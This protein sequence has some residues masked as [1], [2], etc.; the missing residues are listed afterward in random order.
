MELKDFIAILALVATL[1]IFI[2]QHLRLIKVQKQETYQRLELAANEVFR[3]I[4]D[5]AKELA[6]YQAPQ[7]D[8][9]KAL[10]NDEIADN[11]IYQI[12]NLFEMAARLRQ[13]K[14]F[15][16]ELFGSWVAWYN[17][18]PES[19]YFR[20]QWP[21]FRQNYTKEI[22]LIFDD[23]VRTFNINSSEAERKGKFFSHVA[24]VLNCRLI[25]QWLD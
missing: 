10:V 16:H 12:L 3:F 7:G 11:C 23:P 13:A 15:E 25:K 21:K 14:F 24:R 4:A 17:E 18:L 2:L 6:P 8:P 22:R 9:N 20:E 1:V 19:W 5:H